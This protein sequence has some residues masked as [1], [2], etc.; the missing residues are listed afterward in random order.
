VLHIKDGCI[1]GEYDPRAVTLAEL[2]RV[3]YA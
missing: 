1:A 3:V 2:E